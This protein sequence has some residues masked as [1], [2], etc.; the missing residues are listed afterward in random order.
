MRPSFRDNDSVYFVLLSRGDR[1]GPLTK[2]R[3]RYGWSRRP[4]VG[5]AMLT[6]QDNGAAI[7]ISL[8]WI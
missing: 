2:P 3:P 6:V 4:K 1:E 5:T 7:E 8:V